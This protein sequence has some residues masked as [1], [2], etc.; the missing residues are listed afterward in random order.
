[1][2]CCLL[3]TEARPHDPERSREGTYQGRDRAAGRNR[4]RR[5]HR[6]QKV[7]Q[8]LCL[9]SNRLLAA[10]LGMSWRLTEESSLQSRLQHLR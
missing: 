10:R 3:L 1:M 9:Q 6:I 2:F 8:R 4:S 7:R 5:G